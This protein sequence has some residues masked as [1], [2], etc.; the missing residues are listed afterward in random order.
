MQV[1]KHNEYLDNGYSDEDHIVSNHSDREEDAQES[2]ITKLNKRSPKRRKFA[3]SASKEDGNGTSEDQDDEDVPVALPTD[4]SA[5]VVERSTSDEGIIVTTKRPIQKTKLRP[6]TPSQLALSQH[7]TRKTGVIYL[8]RIPPFMRPQ[9]VKHLLASYGTIT[10]LFLTPEPPATYTRRIAAGGNKKKSFLDGWV[11]FASKKDAKIC[12]ESTNGQIVGGKKSGWYHD[13]IWNVKYLKGFKWDDL[14][15][16]VR[17]EEKVREGRLRAEIAKVGR[18][19]KEFLRN[20]ERGKA[21]E[22]MQEKRRNKER[23]KGKANDKTTMV[24][25]DETEP[26]VVKQK[27]GGFERRFRQNEVKSSTV[28][29]RLESQDSD[30]QRVLG[31]IF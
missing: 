4:K 6:L 9:T 19:R 11:E 31:K 15:A 20:W 30:V 10:R 25:G 22:G 13:D 3:V 24:N 27:E 8:S 26:M 14:M 2:K 21:L 16:Q 7:T 29:K 1:R 28:D 23:L 17:D 12:A 18:E 5:V